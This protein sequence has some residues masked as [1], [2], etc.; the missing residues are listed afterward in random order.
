MNVDRPKPV[1]P[2]D[3]IQEMANG[4]DGRCS[5]ALSEPR[6]LGSDVVSS[7]ALSEPRPL[8]SDVVSSRYRRAGMRRQCPV[9]ARR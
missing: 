9:G 7:D 6:P 4:H 1:P 2:P 3:P 5:D 8:G